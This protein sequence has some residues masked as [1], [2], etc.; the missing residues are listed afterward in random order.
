MHNLYMC[1]ST[2]AVLVKL[3][4]DEDSNSLELELIIGTVTYRYIN[5]NG[6]DH[7]KV[8]TPLLSMTFFSDKVIEHFLNT[9]EDLFRSGKC[10]PARLREGVIEV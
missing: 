4:Y 2:D 9:V 5:K 10:Y 3:D 1:L 7:L 6:R 8:E